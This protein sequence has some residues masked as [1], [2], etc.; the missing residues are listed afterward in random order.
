[1]VA[2]QPERAAAVRLGVGVRDIGAALVLAVEGELSLRTVPQLRSV[3]EKHLADRGRVLVDV[4]RLEV[5][6]MPAIDVFPLALSSVYGWP[7]ARLVLFGAR[8]HTRRVLTTAPYLSAAVHLADG[9]DEAVRLLEVRPQRV[10]RRAELEC[11]P[12]AAKWARMLVEAACQDWDVTDAEVV[13]NAR[14][15]VSEL[16]TNAVL[17]AR[18]RSLV[19]IV[20]RRDE[21]RIGVRDHGVDDVPRR[22]D[23]RPSTARGLGLVVVAGVSRSWGVTVHPDGKTVWAFVPCRGGG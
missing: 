9:E 14:I 15:V 1:V 11:E 20:H 10:G 16:V 13:A 19:T 21:L 6:W 12:Q 2:V 3:L 23:G 22:A 7:A 8:G 18:T 17:H 4:S 5:G